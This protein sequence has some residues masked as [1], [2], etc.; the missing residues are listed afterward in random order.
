MAEETQHVRPGKIPHPV[1]SVF[2]RD[3]AF[4][5]CDIITGSILWSSV[6]IHSSLHLIIS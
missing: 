1:L 2:L 4:V 6:S 3:I 5:E